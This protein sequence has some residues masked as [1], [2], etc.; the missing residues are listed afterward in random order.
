M[1]F[2]GTAASG[3]TRPPGTGRIGTGMAS[4]MGSRRGSKGTAPG[5]G[6]GGSDD[7]AEDPTNIQPK[8]PNLTM[9]EARVFSVTIGPG[10]T[11]SFNLD[12]VP[13]TPTTHDFALPLALLGVPPSPHLSRPVNAV[14]LRPKLI[15]SRSV[16]RDLK[17]SSATMR[18]LTA[19]GKITRRMSDGN[20]DAPRLSQ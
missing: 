10:A 2:G 20:T 14:G 6:G 11:L 18:P 7:E 19:S 9:K 16:V 8:N 4:E 17:M 15:M 12:F 13:T 3:G 5:G 1:T